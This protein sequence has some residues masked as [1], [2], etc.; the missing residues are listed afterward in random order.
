MNCFINKWI[1]DFGNG[2]KDGY[3]SE[4][5]NLSSSLKSENQL[6]KRFT[7]SNLAPYNIHQC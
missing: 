2:Y 1:T 6:I 4:A 7:I 5:K 3:R